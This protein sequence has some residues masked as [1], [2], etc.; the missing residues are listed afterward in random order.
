MR[1]VQVIVIK[2]WKDPVAKRFHDIA[3]TRTR[4]LEMRWMNF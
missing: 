2:A 3:K 4:V 1:E